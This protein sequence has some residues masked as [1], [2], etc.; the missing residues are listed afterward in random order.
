MNKKIVVIVVAALVCVAGVFVYTNR[1]NVVGKLVEAK[2]SQYLESSEYVDEYSVDGVT[3]KDGQL[4][5]PELS[6]MI[7]GNSVKLAAQAT[8][9]NPEAKTAEKL[10]ISGISIDNES[11]FSC[12]IES[13]SF[14]GLDFMQTETLLETA[15][16]VNNPFAFQRADVANMACK[17]PDNV[18]LTMESA[19]AEGPFPAG[20]EIPAKSSMVISNILIDMMGTSVRIPEIRGGELYDAS[21]DIVSAAYEPVL[22]EGLFVLEMEAKMADYSKFIKQYAQDPLNTS[23]SFSYMRFKL[24]DKGFSDTMFATLGAMTGVDA[25]SAQQTME[26]QIAGNTTDFVDNYDNGLAIQQALVNYVRQP[27]SIEFV[28]APD[29]PVVFSTETAEDIMLYLADYGMSISVNGG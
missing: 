21:T 11:L 14:D 7:K 19:S 3:Y 23:I 6:M 18:A 9:V 4:N 12:S 26:M 15:S 25:A 17:T 22:V 1:A 27:D 13:I 16:L 10:V 24:D 20:D 28:L 2:I 5:I 29:E 8:G